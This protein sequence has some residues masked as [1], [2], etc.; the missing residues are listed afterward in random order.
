MEPMLLFKGLPVFLRETTHSV[1]DKIMTMSVAV[2]L[3]EL[4]TIEMQVGVHTRMYTGKLCGANG[5][6]IIPEDKC[7]LYSSTCVCTII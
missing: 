5:R 4:E 7:S 6:L 2:C 3:E 1:V